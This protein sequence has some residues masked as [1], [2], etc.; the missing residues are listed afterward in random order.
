MQLG[1]VLQDGGR[2]VPGVL[3][4]VDDG[5]WKKFNEVFLH[6]KTKEQES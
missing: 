3:E 2:T 6:P 5:T 1:Q 4:F